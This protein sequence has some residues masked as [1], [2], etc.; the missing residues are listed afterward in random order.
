MELLFK[1]LGAAS[2]FLAGLYALMLVIPGDQP[3]KIIKK[4]LDITEKFSRK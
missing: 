4:I 3:D 1:Y 2:A